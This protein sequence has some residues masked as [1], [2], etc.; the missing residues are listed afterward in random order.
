M[1]PERAPPPPTPLTGHAAEGAVDAE[2]GSNAQV[3][4]FTAGT[5]SFGRA[6]RSFAMAAGTLGVARAVVLGGVMVQCAA[7][8]VAYARP[9]FG[10]TADCGRASSARAVHLLARCGDPKDWAPL[11][12]ETPAYPKEDDVPLGELFLSGTVEHSAPDLLTLAAS[13]EHRSH[14]WPIGGLVVRSPAG[15]LPVFERDRNLGVSARVTDTGHCV[16]NPP[17]TIVDLPVSH[18]MLSDAPSYAGLRYL[19]VTYRPEKDDYCGS[20]RMVMTLLPFDSR[21][22]KSRDS[23]LDPLFTDRIYGVPTALGF[24]RWCAP[25]GLE[26]HD[27]PSR[28]RVWPG[29]HAAIR[30]GDRTYRLDVLSGVALDDS[31]RSLTEVVHPVD[32][33]VT[34]S[35]LRMDPPGSAPPSAPRA[36]R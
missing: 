3:T 18:L 24:G 22:Y 31:P 23:R 17:G 19:F 4:G 36:P 28:T 13:P 29:G 8:P 11:A 9:P 10:K 14:P 1:R 33:E 5:W 32:E 6:L 21:L 30:D 26:L 7:Y 16:V 15:L 25:A 35:L 34:Y 27:S 2:A 20:T 12:P